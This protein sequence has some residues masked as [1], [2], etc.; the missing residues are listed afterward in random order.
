VP[1]LAEKLIMED[2]NVPQDRACEIR[3]ESGELGDILSLEIEERVTP[4]VDVD[5]EE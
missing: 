3:V 2:M 1:E 4:N 5:V